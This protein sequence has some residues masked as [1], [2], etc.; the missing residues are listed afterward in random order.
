MLARLFGQE[1]SRMSSVNNDDGH[2]HL[3]EVLKD[4][5]IISDFVKEDD[6]K[7]LKIKRS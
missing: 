1:R 5:N 3:L 7:K 6:G 4:N 2:W